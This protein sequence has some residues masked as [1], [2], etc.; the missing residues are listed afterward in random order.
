MNHLAYIP[1]EKAFKSLGFKG[2][3]DRLFLKL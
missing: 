3:C 2:F 1:K